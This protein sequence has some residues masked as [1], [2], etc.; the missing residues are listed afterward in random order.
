MSSNKPVALPDP[1]PGEWSELANFR[2]IDRLVLF[3]EAEA[4]SMPGMEDPDYIIFQDYTVSLRVDDRAVKLT[5]PT[6]MLTDLAS[7]PPI[8]R[9]L[10]E[11]V[12]RH[13]EA[14]IIHDFLYN[15][16]QYVEGGHEPVVRDREFADL[17][18]LR[19]MEAANV[20]AW[21]RWLI[22][23]ALRSFGARA[24]FKKDLEPRFHVPDEPQPRT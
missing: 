22:Y 7:V 11:R 4:I 2:Y 18:M 3:R 12:G 8:F 21:R 14:A 10:V 9:W 15:A 23:R 24:F 5:V 16:W 13:L 20:A 19:A 6:G 17:V 1:Y